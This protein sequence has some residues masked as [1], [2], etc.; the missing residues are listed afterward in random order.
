MAK[1]DVVDHMTVGELVISGLILF[2]MDGWMATILGGCM[3]G[4]AGFRVMES[5]EAAE[6]RARNG[7]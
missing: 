5:N 2:T 4:F 1:R 3:F 6:K 7:A